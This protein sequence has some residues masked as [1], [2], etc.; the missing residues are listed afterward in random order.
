MPLPV[1]L[2]QLIELACQPLT[3]HPDAQQLKQLSQ[4]LGEFA[5]KKFLATRTPDDNA[6]EHEFIV[7]GN[8]LRI[9]AAEPLSGPELRVAIA[10]SFLHDAYYIPRI[11]EWQIRAAWRAVD[12][13]TDPA[14]RQQL[15]TTAGELAISKTQQ[16]QR[17]M[18]GG[19]QLARDWLL[20]PPSSPSAAT[21]EAGDRGPLT[22]A[23]GA[24]AAAQPQVDQQ[25]GETIGGLLTAAEV[26]RCCDLIAHHDDWKLGRPWPASSDRL[27]LACVEGDALWPLHPLGVLADL[28]RPTEAG[29]IRDLLSPPT[30]KSQIQESL[31]TLID[32]RANWPATATGF[33]DDDS[34][35]RTQAGWEL[36]QA[37]RV[38]HRLD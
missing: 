25:I 7:L 6:C 9:A 14:T 24:V 37:W 33:C 21:A 29:T 23:E 22:A 4:H 35:F 18:A 8:V 20:A 16:R 11:T 26:A 10:F 38:Y 1:R 12:L 34:I 5:W 28:E 13:A 2:L 31:Q 27:A 15:E 3:N 19:A 30:W 36:Y 32:Y 17:H